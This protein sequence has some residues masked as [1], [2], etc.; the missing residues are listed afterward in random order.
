MEVVPCWSKARSRTRSTAWAGATARATVRMT[1]WAPCKSKWKAPRIGWHGSGQLVPPSAILC[2]NQLC[3]PETTVDSTPLGHLRRQN[4]GSAVSRHALGLLAVP[5]QA[6]LALSHVEG[7]S[8]DCRSRL[9]CHGSPST[10]LR[11][12]PPLSWLHD[13]TRNGT[14][15]RDC[16]KTV[17]QRE[18][19]CCL[20]TLAPV[21]GAV[22]LA[23]L[24]TRV[25]GRSV[26]RRQV[27]PW[28]R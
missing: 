1:P 24:A 16:S 22:M 23:P 27:N 8:F 14:V 2:S 3:S 4:M 7:L 17:V 21:S 10:S 19:P 5:A 18:G 12:V 6:L 11:P 20:G 9:R 26:W 13:P 15:A 28:R 25:M